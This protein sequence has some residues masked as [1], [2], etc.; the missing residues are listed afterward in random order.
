MKMI[1]VDNVLV[2]DD[3]EYVKFSC[4]LK[5]CKGICC[6]EGDAGAPILETEIET[7]EENIEIIKQY[8][9][10]E[11]LEALEKYGTF[12]YDDDGEFVT[13]LKEKGACTFMVYD[14]DIALCA[15]EKAF[16]DGKINFRKPISCFLYPIRLS[17][18]S[19]GTEVVNYQKWYICQDAL[20]KGE[21]DNVPL[22]IFLK[23]PLIE[24]Y[25]KEW[26]EHLLEQI[27]NTK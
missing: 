7:I 11:G 6:I 8:M 14:G 21:A 16:R 22:Y 13:S 2:S 24:K 10:K 23:E 1:I 25:G 15:I 4:D 27:L 18:L 5:A 20:V 26:Y 12:D 3:I 19:D 17:K 9:D